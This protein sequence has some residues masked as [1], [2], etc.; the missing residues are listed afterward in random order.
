[1]FIK[2]AVHSLHISPRL[3][4]R[5]QRIARTIADLGGY[6]EVTTQHIAEAFQYRAKSYFVV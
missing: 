3:L 1:L 2:Q 5:L 4:H 6:D